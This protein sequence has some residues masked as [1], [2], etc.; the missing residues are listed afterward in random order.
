ME[1]VVRELEPVET[2]HDEFGFTYEDLARAISTT[3]STLHRWR[4]GAGGEPTP[5]YLARLAALGAF[6]EELTHTFRDR[7]DA[8][9]WLD[10][11]MPALRGQSP[12][13]MV[14]AGHVDRVTGVLYAINAGVAT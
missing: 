10:E 13:Q 2:L 6:L 7:P 14:L 8:R 9:A 3:E 4:K 5:V 12:R 11:R 1:T